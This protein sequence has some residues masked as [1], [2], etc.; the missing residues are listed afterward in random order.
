MERLDLGLS[1]A[2]IDELHAAM[3]T[4][5]GGEID[6]MEFVTKLH[7]RDS[8]RVY[9][10]KREALKRAL[11]LRCTGKP[12]L[13]PRS[14]EMAAQRR[15]QLSFQAGR[16]VTSGGYTALL[17]YAEQNRSLHMPRSRVTTPVKLSCDG[18]SEE[19][20]PS[21]DDSKKL[22]PLSPSLLTSPQ[23]PSR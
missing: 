1:A 7:D 22:P 3:D 14:L 9:T 4:D 17:Y 10:K 12:E 21:W 18:S 11:S 5:G 23:N 13:T 15:E 8:D 6:Y 2:Q 20:K 16:P 19:H